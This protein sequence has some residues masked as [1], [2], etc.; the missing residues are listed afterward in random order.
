M[1]LSGFLKYDGGWCPSLFKASIAWVLGIGNESACFMVEKSYGVL[2]EPVA[3]G[4]IPY[5]LQQEFDFLLT[6]QRLARQ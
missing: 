6:A 1:A 5:I 2:P 4:T 3:L